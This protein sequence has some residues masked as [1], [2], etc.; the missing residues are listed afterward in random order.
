[1]H[2]LIQA[3]AEI[4]VNRPAGY[5]FA[6]STWRESWRTL[7]ATSRWNSPNFFEIPT[8]STRWENPGKHISG[9]VVL[10]YTVSYF[11][12]RRRPALNVLDLRLRLAEAAA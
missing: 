6:L 5:L 11:V 1:M 4:C 3:D 9:T 2:A 7:S 12:V 10:D 8:I